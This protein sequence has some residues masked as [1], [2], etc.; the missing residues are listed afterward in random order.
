MSCICKCSRST[1]FLTYSERV[2]LWNSRKTDCTYIAL[3]AAKVNNDRNILTVAATKE[4]GQIQKLSAG[5]Y[6]MME[7]E[8]GVLMVSRGPI[9]E[10]SYDEI[11][12]NTKNLGWACDFQK[13]IL[14]KS[15][16]KLRTKLCKTY[17]KLT[18]TLQ[19]SYENI[20]FA[21]SDVIRETL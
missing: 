1:D 16:E 17:D 21:A 15:Y 2:H 8:T 5:M 10:K 11:M 20:K 7:S 12:K 14:Q 9:F 4:V 6:D 3:E 18:T 13:K 19:V